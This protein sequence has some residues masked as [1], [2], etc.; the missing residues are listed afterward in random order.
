[1]SIDQTSKLIEII[2][3]EAFEDIRSEILS[4]Y[5]DIPIALY[6]FEVET[7]I[8]HDAGPGCNETLVHMGFNFTG[9]SN[10]MMLYVALG[11]GKSKND[12]WIDEFYEDEVATVL[13]NIN[14]SCTPGCPCS[15]ECCNKPDLFCPKHI[16]NEDF[17]EDCFVSECKNC[18]GSCA[19][20]L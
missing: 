19:C 7:I 6:D 16:C 12:Y 4:Q 1:M 3:D 9:K 2:G 5:G 8:D 11:R 20:D 17:C 18:H 14:N 15:G 10:P 13:S